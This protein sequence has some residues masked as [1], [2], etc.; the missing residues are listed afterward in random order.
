MEISWSNVVVIGA[1]LC[2][3]E[4]PAK[5]HRLPKDKNELLIEKISG[6]TFTVAPP[7]WSYISYIFVAYFSTVYYL[8]G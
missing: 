2:A 6:F 7:S 3:R 5:S 4:N 8:C 1:K